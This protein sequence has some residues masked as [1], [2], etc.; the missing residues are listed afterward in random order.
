M[1]FLEALRTLIVYRSRIGVLGRRNMRWTTLRVVSPPFLALYLTESNVHWQS[2]LVWP[3][4]GGVLRDRLA[5]NL[6]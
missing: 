4:G 6:T 3:E 1:F 5:Q 2:R